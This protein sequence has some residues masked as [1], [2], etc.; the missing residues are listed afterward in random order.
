MILSIRSEK[1]FDKSQHPFLITTL[2]K[3]GIKGTYLNIIRPYMKD[4]QV[5]SSMGKNLQ[6]FLYG[7]EQDS[8]VHF[9][10]SY[11]THLEVLASAIR[12]RKEIKGIQISKEEVKLSLFAD[13]IILL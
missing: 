12:Q 3:V 2:N 4:P 5:I 9:H 6:L 10:H 13:D 11:L 8:D 1:T 7:Q